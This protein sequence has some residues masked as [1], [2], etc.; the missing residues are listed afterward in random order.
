[1]VADR[2]TGSWFKAAVAGDGVPSAGPLTAAPP[3]SLERGGVPSWAGSEEQARNPTTTTIEKRPTPEEK[4]DLLPMSARRAGEAGRALEAPPKRC[5]ILHD[6]IV[7][8]SHPHIIPRDIPACNRG[9]RPDA[10]TTQG[11]R[12]GLGTSRHR[13]LS[14]TR[15]RG[16]PGPY[17]DRHAGSHPFP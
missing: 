15:G 13:A 6:V 1:M 17:V 7:V 11:T 5:G 8:I 14:S 16:F 3:V 4:N 12:A 9:G 2:T 10:C